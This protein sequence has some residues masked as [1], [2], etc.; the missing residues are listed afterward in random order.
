MCG[1]RQFTLC[2]VWPTENGTHREGSFQVLLQTAHTARLLQNSY[3]TVFQWYSATFINGNSAENNTEENKDTV[4][5]ATWESEADETSPYFI[6]IC[7]VL[8]GHTLWSITFAQK[9][10]VVCA[11]SSTYDFLSG[12]FVGENMS[13]QLSYPFTV[14]WVILCSSLGF[15]QSKPLPSSRSQCVLRRNGEK[16]AVELEAFHLCQWQVFY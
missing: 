14:R 12:I 5:S 1:E 16:T 11:S 9:L 2:N 4:M 15:G 10:W 8:G 6:Y 13:W 7:L 3:T